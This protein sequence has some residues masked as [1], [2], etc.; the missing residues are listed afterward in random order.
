MPFFTFFL[1]FFKILE[2][3]IF[4][5]PKRT[6][7]KKC[8]HFFDKFTFFCCHKTLK[9]YIYFKNIYFF[10]VLKKDIFSRFRCFHNQNDF[11][12]EVRWYTFFPVYLWKKYQ[13][14]WT[15]F[16]AKKSDFRCQ[17]ASSGPKHTSK[18][19]MHTI[20]LTKSSVYSRY[21]NFPEGY[22]F[23]DA[24]DLWYINMWKHLKQFKMWN[25][26]STGPL[27]PCFL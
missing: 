15:A 5:F 27:G 23:W 1:F 16:T 19:Q 13:H 4:N 10:F 12:K 25:I 24:A 7:F 26:Q 6:I 21:L 17:L 14:I 3:F 11:I 9:Y 22:G 18:R 8:I 2:Y 20:Y